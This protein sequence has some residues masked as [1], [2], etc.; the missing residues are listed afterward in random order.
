MQV[1]WITKGSAP[2]SDGEGAPTYFG[3]QAVLTF[4]VLDPWLCVTGFHRICFST[5]FAAGALDN[6]PVPL[7]HAQVDR[8]R[9]AGFPWWQR[10]CLGRF[11]ALDPLAL[12]HRLSPVS[13]FKGSPAVLTGFPV[14]DPRLC[15][16][17]FHGVYLC[18]DNT[19][20]LN[21][22]T[23]ERYLNYGDLMPGGSGR[24]Q[25]SPGNYYN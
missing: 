12:H 20:N 2:S 15:V 13:P 22:N 6:F 3:S 4:W 11:L 16:P 14:L 1:L 7:R 8:D 5:G 25:I 10:G 9:S 24:C 21:R 23:I 18:L 17:R 19:T